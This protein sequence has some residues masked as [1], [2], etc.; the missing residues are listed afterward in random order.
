[1]K[2]IKT[3]KID[4]DKK[5]FEVIP[6]VQYDSNTRFLHIQLLNE[7]TPF[8]ITGCSVVLSGTK[9]DG[10][11]IF[12]SCDIINPEIGFIQAE[13]TEQMNAIPGYIDCEIKI[14][15]GEGVLTSK[16]FTIKVTA[17]QTSRAVESTGEFK[18]LTDA[19]SKVNNIDNKADKKELEVERKRIDNI[20]RL[21]QGSTT[22][23]AELIDG[24]TGADGVIYNNIGEAIRTQIDNNITEYIAL[25]YNLTNGGYV[26]Y[27]NGAIAIHEG[28][29]AYSDFIELVGSKTIMIKNLKYPA[30]DLAGLCFYNKNKQFISGYQYNKNIDLSLEIPENAKYIRFT[31]SRH[32]RLSTIKVYQSNYDGIIEGIADTDDIKNKLG[33]VIE[34]VEL[35]Q[36]SNNTYIDATGGV[37]TNGGNYLISEPI[38]VKKGTL[39]NVVAK[40]YLSAVS[41]ISEYLGNDTKYKPLLMSKDGVEDYSMSISEDMEIVICSHSTKKWRLHKNESGSGLAKDI[42]EKTNAIN[43]IINSS[44]AMSIGETESNKYI[45]YSNGQVV[46]GGTPHLCC[47]DYIDITNIVELIIKNLNYSGRDQ[48]G[49]CFYNKDKKFISGYQYNGE[50]DLKL[51]TPINAKYIRFTARVAN[52]SS[53][54]LLFNIPETIKQGNSTRKIY[55]F[56]YTTSKYISYGN[57]ELVNFESSSLSA[58]DYIELSKLANTIT[59][60]NLKYPNNDN[61]G[62]CFYNSNKQF[63]SGY[64]YNRDTDLSLKI[65]DDAKY[66]RFSIWTSQVNGIVVYDEATIEEK[67]AEVSKNLYSLENDLNNGKDEFDYCQ[68]FHKIVG[69]GDS[70]MSGELAF[71]SEEEQKNKFVDLHKYS[72]LSNLCK[73]IGATPVHYSS[74]GRTTK[75]WLDGYLNAMKSETVLP[76]AYYV[77]LGT[78]D[79]SYIS[80]G[81]NE[82][83][84]TEAETFY[85]MYSKIIREI[86]GFNPN[87]KIF[88]CSL[89]FSKTSQTVINY[90]Q[91]IKEISDTYGCYYIDFLNNC[92]HKYNSSLISVGHFTSPGYARVGK[93]IQLLTNDI[94]KNNLSDFAFIG[95]NH[96][97]I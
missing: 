17:S 90:C 20:A 49:L 10:N 31:V 77:A 40:G 6:S 94:I 39:I 29:L 83:I 46:A 80:L 57:G 91:A 62:L 74:G 36:H 24:R 87:A 78:N 35:V 28:N 16:N 14:Y 68:I 26:Q 32:D 19:L 8:N 48:G 59:I 23:D 89:Y 7:S 18:A 30:K 5:N 61:A 22:G 64:Q 95:L 63:I 27:L 13:V 93:D 9:E 50:T 73:N 47:T 65:P 43:E 75:S 81:T 60:K 76:S 92:S 33:M 34:E 12:N 53:M 15:D 21:E 45:S 72:W 38:T 71:W 84:G 2:Y 58:T 66:L 52:V 54:G 37:Q 70:L 69:I 25:P 1:M 55:D 88:C 67:F 41:I 44:I 82:D 85:G 11:P 97:D 3:L 4:I 79:M 42:G 56:S 86:Q 96:K 51:T